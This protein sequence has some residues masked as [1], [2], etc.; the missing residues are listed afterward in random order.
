VQTEQQLQQQFLQEQKEQNESKGFR[1]LIVFQEEDTTPSS[2]L[3]SL[4]TGQ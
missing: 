1:R 4:S 3:T 2:K